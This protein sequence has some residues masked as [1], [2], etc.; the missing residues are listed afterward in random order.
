M[1]EVFGLLLLGLLALALSSRGMGQDD[2]T[3]ADYA[4]WWGDDE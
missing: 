2:G 1:M 4:D 3:A